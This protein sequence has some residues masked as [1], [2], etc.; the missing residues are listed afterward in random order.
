MTFETL[1]EEIDYIDIKKEND[2]ELKNVTNNSKDIENGDVFVA[3]V[4]KLSDGH[5]YI[6]DA[7]KNGASTVVYQGLPKIK[8]LM[9][10]QLIYAFP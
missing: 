4:G 6:D 7:I 8:H 3:I 10:L 9:V 2:Q 1:V 5:K